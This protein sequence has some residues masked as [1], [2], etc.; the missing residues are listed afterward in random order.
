MVPVPWELFFCEW[1]SVVFL[2]SDLFGCPYMQV[3][4]GRSWFFC[5][6]L[7]QSVSYAPFFHSKWPCLVLNYMVTSVIS[8]LYTLDLCIFNKIVLFSLHFSRIPVIFLDPSYNIFKACYNSVSWSA[9]L[10]TW[11]CVPVSILFHGALLW[12]SSFL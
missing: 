12:L 11:L 9:I 5:L 4:K 3:C 8:H 7:W 10:C 2:W 1:S 6:L